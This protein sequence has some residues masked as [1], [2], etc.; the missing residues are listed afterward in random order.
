MKYK[1]AVWLDNY[2]V[3]KIEDG[4]APHLPKNSNEAAQYA[5]ENLVATAELGDPIY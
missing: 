5:V 1:W 4:M 2:T 3:F